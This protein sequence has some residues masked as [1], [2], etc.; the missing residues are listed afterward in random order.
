MRRLLLGVLACLG[1]VPALAATP[2]E[3]QTARDRAANWLIANQ[4][5]DGRWRGAPGLQVHATAA[6][7]EAL[8]AGG[9][10]HTPAFQRAVSWLQNAEPDGV[11]ALSRQALALQAVGSTVTAQRAAQWLASQRNA[12]DGLWGAYAGF[13]GST[14]DTAL[15]LVALKAAG[16]TPVDV[17]RT[18]SEIAV[19]Q[20]N[21]TGW[22]YALR[23][24]TPFERFLPRSHV[25]PTSYVV[26]ALRQHE[27]SATAIANALAWLKSRQGADG[28]VIDS[29]GARGALTTAMAWRALAAATPLGRD[30]PAARKAIDYLVAPG[31]QTSDGS[32]KGDPFV[33]AIVLEVLATATGTTDSDGD[34]VPDNMERLIGSD[35][36]RVP[37]TASHPDVSYQAWRGVP[38][39]FALPFD[40]VAQC[41]TLIANAPPPGIGF[42]SGPNHFVGTPQQEGR[43]AFQLS[44]RT[45]RDWERRVWVEVDVQMP[46]FRTDADPFVYADLLASLGLERLTGGWQ[47]L[48]EDFDND[49]RLDLVMYVNGSSER[50]QPPGCTACPGP[51]WGRVLLLRDAA[52]APVLAAD[53]SLDAPIA[54][55]LRSMHAFD[56]NGDGLRDVLL[57]LGRTGTTSPD[58]ADQPPPFRSLVLLRN[59]SSPGYLR[60]V[61]VTAEVGLARSTDNEVVVLDANRD[62][63]PDLVVA[64]RTTAAEVWLWNPALQ[65]YRRSTTNPALGVLSRPVAGDFSGDRLLDIATLDAAKGIRVLENKG[66][67]TFGAPQSPFPFTPLTLRFDPAQTRLR[68]GDI[69]GDGQADVVVFERQVIMLQGMLGGLGGA[70]PVWMPNRNGGELGDY[71]NDGRPDLV[72]SRLDGAERKGPALISNTGMQP[73]GDSSGLPRDVIGFDSPV[74]IDLDGDGALDLLLPNSSNTNYKLLNNGPNRNSVTVILRARAGQEAL[75]ARVDVTAGGT[76]RRQWLTADHG[77]SGRLHFG[78][79]TAGSARVQ[80]TWP[81]GTTS[82]LEEVSGPVTI[83]QP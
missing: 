79:G 50:L 73:L 36:R 72:L 53:N 16:L 13:Q 59:E 52:G 63:L 11:D 2:A 29:D 56:Y 28:G 67:G 18:F 6:A 4:Q 38:A 44:Y 51:A 83:V 34:G 65:A 74:F 60:L 8:L 21:G 69:N 75:G 62:A 30:D 45:T 17:D 35:P 57:V 71:D 42:E 32:Y 78:L 22:P 12:A 40:D 19:A 55:A 81:D 15:G 24:A 23:N 14:P 82:E 41:C 27:R 61:D 54:G 37:T 31:I 46:V 43:F 39:G 7:V 33:T 70:S 68:S 80:V 66:N 10:T 25:A 47:V 76:T 5:P 9:M 48:A 3:V 49:D 26:V 64:N 20:I 58:P 77:R 1:A